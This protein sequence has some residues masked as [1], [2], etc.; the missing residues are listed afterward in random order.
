MSRHGIYDPVDGFIPDDDSP[1]EQKP[2]TNADRIRAMTDE[3][4]AEWVVKC[5]DADIFRETVIGT[6]MNTVE[7]WLDWLKQEVDNA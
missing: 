3:E 4:L 1:E 2:L 5:R 6:H 7:E